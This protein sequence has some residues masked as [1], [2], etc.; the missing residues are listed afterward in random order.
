MALWAENSSPLTTS[1]SHLV[2]LPVFW[3]DSTANPTM[4]WDKWLDLFHVAMMAKYS[5]SKTELTREANQQNA[6]VRPFMGDLHEDPANEKIISVMYLALGEAARKQFMDKYPNTA[7]WELKESTAV[8][9]F[10]WRV[11]RK[12]QSRTLDRHRTTW[13]NPIS[14]SARS[15]RACSHLQI[16]WNYYYVSTRHVQFT[17]EKVCKFYKVYIIKKCRR[18]YALSLKNPIRHWNL[19]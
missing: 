15:E 17:H 9:N 5:I 11:I 3:N 10:V 16:W 7:L 6:R 19:P 14:N 1:L 2:G 13:R 8:D 12:N 4:D 18:N